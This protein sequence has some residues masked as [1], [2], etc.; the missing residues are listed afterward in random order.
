MTQK[1][2]RKMTISSELNSAVRNQKLSAD[3][4]HEIEGFV[5]Q[6]FST[7]EEYFAIVYGSYA[8]SR[9]KDTSDIDVMF[10]SDK[11][12]EARMNRCI[13]FV[14]DL[15]QRHGLPLDTEIKYEHKVLIPL[16]FLADAVTGVGFQ[17]KDGSYHIPKIEKTRECLESEAL[18][19]RF[20]H[21]MMTHEHIF[22]CG[23]DQFYNQ[24]QAQATKELVKAITMARDERVVTPQSLA[25][26][27]LANGRDEG[28]FYLGFKQDEYL[29]RLCANALGSMVSA[30][31]ATFQGNQYDLS[32]LW[33][34][35]NN[36]DIRPSNEL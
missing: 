14:I 34:I 26:L 16:S 7:E 17:R 32:G 15:H 24:L 27:L 5:K 3:L 19:Q 35:E 25:E 36:V 29:S 13:D 21:G 6:E 30:N 20:L 31:E 9:Q 23:N 11:I 1:S 8:K 2:K 22:V 10:V 4:I 18:R 28:D 12:G 33:G